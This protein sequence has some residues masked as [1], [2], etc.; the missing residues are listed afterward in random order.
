MM[1]HSKHVLFS[2][3]NI[4]KES[5]LQKHRA[6]NQSDIFVLLRSLNK[7]KNSGMLPKCTPPIKKCPWLFT[8]IVQ[9]EKFKKKTTIIINEV[10]LRL[11]E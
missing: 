7:Y 10:R 3:K 8:T 1:F 9:K 6:V 4:L 2:L 11:N 5:E